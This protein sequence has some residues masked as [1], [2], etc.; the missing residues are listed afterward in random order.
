[1][2]HLQHLY[3]CLRVHR[4]YLISKHLL[5]NRCSQAIC[6]CHDKIS[7]MILYQSRSLLMVEDLRDNH[8]SLV[9]CG[10][11]QAMFNYI[12]WVFLL[13]ELVDVS[14]IPRS[15]NSIYLRVFPMLKNW[16]NSIIS[17]GTL[18]QNTSILFNNINDSL[19]VL[20]HSSLRNEDLNH[21]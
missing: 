21:T 14:E 4:P 16:L 19:L 3:S 6:M 8:V 5:Q 18:C 17:K 12:W 9:F 15:H 13:A 7:K 2:Y 1:M 20:C 11:V 10:M